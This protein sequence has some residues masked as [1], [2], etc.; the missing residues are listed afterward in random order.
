MRNKMKKLWLY[1]FLSVFGFIMVYPLIWLFTSSFKPNEEIFLSLRLLPSNFVWDSY[2]E[3]WQGSKQFTFT[4]F[5]INS[6]KMVIPTVFFTVFSS[7]LVGYGFARFKFPMKKILMTL[8]LSTLMLP[9]AVVMIPKF[10]LFNNFEW[11]NSYKPFHIP[12]MFGGYPFFIFM[13]TQFFRGLPYELDESA[14]I[15]G[16]SSFGILVRVLLPLCKP[17]V[18]SAAIF[19]FVWTWSDFINPL[20]YINS[21]SKYTVTLGLN[22]AVDNMTSVNWNQLAAMSVLALIPPI[23]VFFFAQ[24]FFV[25]GVITTGLKG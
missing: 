4:T 25:E 13:L 1:I 18:V 15:D 20:I 22:M 12:A 6:F 9:N 2:S 14:T 21:I 19:Q 23:L 8:M 7:V 5:F 17:A 16:C 11:L 3:G 10:I 24:K